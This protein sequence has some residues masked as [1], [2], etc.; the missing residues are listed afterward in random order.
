MGVFAH[1]NAC[2]C[3]RVCVCVC[4]CVRS[5]YVTEND[6]SRTRVGATPPCVC[7]L[8][9]PANAYVTATTR[10]LLQQWRLIMRRITS[11]NRRNFPLQLLPTPRQPFARPPSHCLALSFTLSLMALR[12][13]LYGLLPFSAKPPATSNFNFNPGAHG[14]RGKRSS[15]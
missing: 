7:K 2:V 9:A 6:G 4:E 5:L 13:I 1:S 12:L 8:L 10:G 3:R 11:H 14:A 15:E